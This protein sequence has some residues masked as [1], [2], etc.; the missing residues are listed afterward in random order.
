MATKKTKYLGLFFPKEVGIRQKDVRDLAT[1]THE[2]GHHI[3]YTL[4]NRMSKNPPNADIRDE[5]MKLGKALYGETKPPGGYKSEGWAEFLRY[6]LTGDQANTQAP[7]TF[8]W[9][10]KY[11]KDNPETAK[12]LRNIK[13]MVEVWRKQGAEA[14]IESQISR[15]K[16][17]GSIMDIAERSVLWVNIAFRDEL[18]A[19]KTAMKRAGIKEGDLA[20][21]EN[22]YQVAVAR[23]DKAGAVARRFV[24][25][26]TTDLAGNP[27]GKGLREILEPVAKDID[28]FTRWMMAA[29][30]RLLHSRGINPGI[31]REDANYV[32]QKHDSP[33]WQDT[34]KEI[35]AWNDRLLDY[36]SEAGGL[37]ADAR[38][39][40]R[41]ANPI[42]VPFMRA[43]QAGEVQFKSGIGR[44]VAKTPKAVKAIKGSGREIIDILESMVT[45]AQ[46]VIGIA[47]KTEVAVAL[48]KV[49]NKPGTASMIWEVPAPKEATTFQAEQLKKDIIALARKRMGLDPGEISSGMLEHWDELLTVYS[50]ASHYYGKDNIVSLVIDGKRRF[51]EVDPALYRAMEGLDRYNLPWFFDLLFGKAARAVRLGATGLN[52]GFGLIRNFL[53]DSMTFT[54]LSKHAKGGPVSAGSGIMADIMHTE[55]AEKFK[56]LGGKM[57]SQIL[58]DRRAANNLKKEAL[59]STVKGKVIYHIAHPIDALRELFGVTEA[60][61]RIG[62]FRAALKDAEE[63]YGK[64]SKD[65]AVYALNQAQDVTTNFS[66]HGSI[67]KILN[68]V[69]PFF[70]AGIQGPDKI[71]RTFAERPTA[72][73]FKAV[74]AL[75]IPAILLWWRE[76]DEEYYKQLSPYERANYLHFRIP[77]TEKVIRLPVPFELG[78]FFQA[79]PV[80]AID[81]QYRDDPKLVNEMFSESLR[82]TN[83][84]DWPAAWGP[85]IEVLA[86]RDYNGR[87]IV[88]LR[89]EDKLPEDQYT[90]YTTA[91]MK[92]I[93]GVINYSPA[94]LEHLVNSYSGGLYLRLARTLDLREKSEITVN[95]LPIISTLFLRESYAPRAELNRFYERREELNRLHRSGKLPWQKSNQ[96]RSYNSIASRLSDLWKKLPD[97]KTQDEKKAIYARMK[98]YLKWAPSEE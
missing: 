50:N 69:I 64:G 97:A 92:Q 38:K 37:E 66:R 83:P 33:L 31:S 67:G 86:N 90:Q 74:A 19:I 45:Q 98:E 17:R 56:D 46:K 41:E 94:K 26:N 88:P 7:A 93:G 5:L 28:A 25:N 48:A 49:A 6:Y 11:L 1:M 65:A 15:K 18:V 40:I 57:S 36:L 91:L 21:G 59:V 79:A 4:N 8:K 43:F 16:R 51:Y 47:H 73:A 62:E 20:P 89:V 71:L 52:P 12:H 39:R 34:L 2:V 58:A 32:Y 70:N 87:P 9:F 13:D 22:P 77:G 96:R 42:Y 82:Q 80:A 60:G 85:I 10:Q 44:G 81:A 30:A 53:R 54:V 55:A 95:D 61:T 72:T 3:D 68:Q 14:R 23:A 27:T 63:R 78:Y 24:L 84:V 35:T 29:R 76:K 75:T